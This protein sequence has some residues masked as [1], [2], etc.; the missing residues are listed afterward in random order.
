MSRKGEERFFYAE[1]G[2]VA[3]DLLH[4][5]LD[6]FSAA[7]ALRGAHWRYL[8]SAGYLAHLGLE[9]LLK[10]WLLECNGRFRETHFFKSLVQDAT[11]AEP[12]FRL[13]AAQN[14]LLEYLDGLEKLRYPIRRTAANRKMPIEIGDEDIC[15]AEELGNEIWNRLPDELIHRYKTIPTNRKGDGVVM[16]KPKGLPINRDFLFAGRNTTPKP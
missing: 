13:T 10:S 3:E 15:L 12:S 14:R 8:H 16:R 2:Y 11:L 6:H 4:Y 7:L 1:D 9:L 5:G